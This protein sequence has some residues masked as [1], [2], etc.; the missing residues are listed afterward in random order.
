MSFFML[1]VDGNGNP[2]QLSPVGTALAR[3]VVGTLSSNVAVTLNTS[4]RFL[5]MYTKSQD[6]YLRWGT[7][8]TAT[9]FD[10][11]LPSGQVVDLVVPRGSSDF[12]TINFL[13]AAASGTV[14][15]VQK[16]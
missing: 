13:E 16:A 9:N 12:G 3:Q 8:A 5:R 4:A 10:E 11:Y 2:V 15:L 14:V 6:V 1:H 7:A